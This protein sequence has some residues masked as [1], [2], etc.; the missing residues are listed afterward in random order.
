[1]WEKRSLAP[2][3]LNAKREWDDIDEATVL[4]STHERKLLCQSHRG[5][6]LDTLLGTQ[7]CGLR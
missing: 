1:M 2:C 3:C 6:G 5:P 4:A 7:A